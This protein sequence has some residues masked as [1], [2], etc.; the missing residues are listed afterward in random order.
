MRIVCMTNEAQLPMMKNM[1]NSAMKV[2]IP[3]NLF[4]CYILNSQVEVAVYGSLQFN[5]ITLKKLEVIKMNMGLDH[6]ILWVDND[7]VFF[8]NCLND[9]LSKRGNFVM[10]D[11]L[12]G[13]CTGFFLARSSY[14]ANSVIQKSVQWLTNCTNKNANDQHAFNRVY[15]QII[16][17]QITK[18]ST[19]EYPN[20]EIY[21]NKGKTTKAK[22]VHCNYLPT[23]AEKVQRFKDHGMWDESDTA[24]LLTNRYLI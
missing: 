18:L 19:E 14:F 4:H 11:D 8:E 23:T 12:W 20:G 21:F 1:L 2:G 6:E 10:Q 15:P 22:M 24:F 17:I 3:M 5:S 9:V 13:A 7:I 16:G